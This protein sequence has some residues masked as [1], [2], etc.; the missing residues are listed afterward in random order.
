MTAPLRPLITIGPDGVKDDT[1]LP[2]AASATGK[3]PEALATVA[4]FHLI[5]ATKQGI[6]TEAT[7]SEQRRSIF[8]PGISLSKQR[9]EKGSKDGPLFSCRSTPSTV[10]R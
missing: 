5:G 4:R 8:I 1:S 7:R 9:E 10:D 3:L 2:G 6:T